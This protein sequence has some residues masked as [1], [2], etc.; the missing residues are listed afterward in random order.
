MAAG[1]ATYGKKLYRT[2]SASYPKKHRP[3]PFAGD[4]PMDTSQVCIL[5]TELN[6]C[7]GDSAF[8]ADFNAGFTAEA[9]VHVYRLG[10][11]I[12]HFINLRRT[13][14]Y[15]FFITRT[16]VFIDDNFPHSKTSM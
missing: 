8:R 12:N 14:I 13:C 3:V 10:F 1:K 15:T 5:Q 9:L 6:L 16:F 7:Y 2:G 11:S 4:R